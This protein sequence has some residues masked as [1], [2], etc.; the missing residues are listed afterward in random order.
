M[1][2]FI[3]AF[4]T[5]LYIIPAMGFASLPV[6]YTVCIL[7]NATQ[8]MAYT[9]MLSAMMDKSDRTTAATDYTIQVFIM[10]LGGIATTILSGMLAPRTGYA[11]TF[12]VSAAVSV[13]SVF[14]ITQFHE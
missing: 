8:S 13:L 14:L 2:G 12:M 11:P 4:T 9:A 5:L 3:P 6:L 7:V 1:F 10:F